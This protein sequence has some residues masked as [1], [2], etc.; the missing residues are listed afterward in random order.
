MRLGNDA[1]VF[2]HHF[3]EKSLSLQGEMKRNVFSLNEQLEIGLAAPK[4]QRVSSRT[5]HS[6]F[7]AY[8]R[9]IW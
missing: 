7:A 5:T 6:T 3:P 1:H 4:T 2:G 8:M 9:E